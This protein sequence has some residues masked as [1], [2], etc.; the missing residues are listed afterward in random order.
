M[1]GLYIAKIPLKLWLKMNDPE[2]EIFRRSCKMMNDFVSE[3]KAPPKGK[4]IEKLI[5]LDETLEVVVD[6]IQ[7]LAESLDEIKNKEEIIFWNSQITKLRKDVDKYIEIHVESFEKNSV[8]DRE[9]L[10]KA[11]QEALALKRIAGLDWK[12]FAKVKG[13][14]IA[15]E[16]SEVEVGDQNE[17]DDKLDD[18]SQFDDVKKVDN[19][20][21]VSEHE[22]DDNLKDKVSLE[23]TYVLEAAGNYEDEFFDDP[24]ATEAD[25]SSRDDPKLPAVTFL[26]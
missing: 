15:C 5:K 8:N 23:E 17:P 10:E 2:D 21:E 4:V 14:P 12:G 18:N 16:V 22:S 24:E 3:V 19:T 26:T 1:D 11:S 13:Y 20:T 25:A 7:N 9:Y 6:L